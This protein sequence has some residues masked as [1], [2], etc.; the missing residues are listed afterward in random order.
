MLARIGIGALIGVI[1]MT[2]CAQS[3]ALTSSPLTVPASS[4]STP[5][6]D[7]PSDPPDDDPAP[8]NTV[9]VSF[10]LVG[11]MTFGTS[12]NLPPGGIDSILGHVRGELQ[13]DLTMG[14]LETVIGNVSAIK[15]TEDSDSRHE[16]VAHP[17][18]ARALRDAGFSAVSV[19]NN[20]TYDAG[21]AGAKAT[22]QALSDAGIKWT[23]RPGQITY[24][25]L[26]ETGV[27]V[28]LLAFAPYA[29]SSNAVNI[30]NAA[31]MV[32]K[33]AKNADLVVVYMHVGGEGSDRQNVKPGSES[34]LGENRGDPMALS[35]A[36]IDAGADLVFGSGPHVLRGMQWYKGHLIAYSLGNFC[37]YHTFNTNGPLGLSAV[38]HVTL[39]SRGGFIQ[40]SL[41]PL[42][43]I[44]AGTPQIDATRKAIDTVRQLSKA[45]FGG[46]GAV[47]LDVDGTI[48][49][50]N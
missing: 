7:V 47:G 12:R 13:S 11:D 2:G 8:E 15:C 28:G 50:P 34:F 49:P 23:G 46:K 5:N 24:M 20:H 16:F 19:A 48:Q 27:K 37:G 45:D 14:N 10:S 17:S 38:L 1:T 33:A 26:E 29:S 36:V 9:T 42:K 31:Q 44:G 41:T 4:T 22:E 6:T 39:D 40:G 43:L 35:H 21:A 18:T 25:T 32:A 3:D 30:V